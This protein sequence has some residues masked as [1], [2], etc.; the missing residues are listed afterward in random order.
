MWYLLPSSAF[1]FIFLFSRAPIVFNLANSLTPCFLSG[2]HTSH[3]QFVVVGIF[4]QVSF[5]KPKRA[6]RGGEW[7]MGVT[8]TTHNG[9]DQDS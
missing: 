6:Q 3:T 7:L 1:H 9:D 4:Y 5:E 2:S 8:H